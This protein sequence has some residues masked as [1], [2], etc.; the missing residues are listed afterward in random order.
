MENN[1]VL[2]NISVLSDQ[3]KIYIYIYKH[4]LQ[5]CQSHYSTVTLF[6]R[7]FLGRITGFWREMAIEGIRLVRVFVCSQQPGQ[8]SLCLCL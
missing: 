5:S 8:E 4:Y 3:D 2:N 1:A 6:N 7:L